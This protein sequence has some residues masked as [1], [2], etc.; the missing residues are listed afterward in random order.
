MYKPGGRINQYEQ[1][2]LNSPKRDSICWEL[3]VDRCHMIR[4]MHWGLCEAYKRFCKSYAALTSNSLQVLDI[5]EEGQTG[6]ERWISTKT[7]KVELNDVDVVTSIGEICFWGAALYERLNDKPIWTT[8]EK[9]YELAFR[10]V[11]NA[12]KHGKEVVNFFSNQVETTIHPHNH[13]VQMGIVV[14]MSWM[15]DA[16]I[17]HSTRQKDQVKAYK[18]LLEAKPINET[19]ERFF[20][21]MDKKAREIYD[22]Y[23]PQNCKETNPS[24]RKVYIRSFT[25]LKGELPNSQPSEKE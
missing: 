23:V 19:I 22:N 6:S 17:Q 10:R 5:Y 4:C 25:L 12:M 20:Y 18:N 14:K 8:E 9:Q 24:Q 16:K 2:F 7:I 11:Y 21:M 13:T 3:T 15:D 1:K